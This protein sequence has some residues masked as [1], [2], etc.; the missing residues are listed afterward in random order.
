MQHT[1]PGVLLYFFM[2]TREKAR[3]T[4]DHNLGSL[5]EIAERVNLD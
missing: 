2:G 3:P 4:V 1:G 5:Q